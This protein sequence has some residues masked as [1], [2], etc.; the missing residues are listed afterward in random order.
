[1]REQDNE[2]SW[3]RA[4]LERVLAD[5]PMEEFLPAPRAL[6]AFEAAAAASVDPALVMRAAAKLRGGGKLLPAEQEALE[7][8]IR[9]ARPALRFDCGRL[10]VVPTLKLT[11]KERCSIEAMAPGIASVGWSWDIP[12][13]TAFQVAPR[14]L[15]T[16]A[17]VAEKLLHA[18]EDLA[19]GRFVAR[20]DA[21]AQGPRESFP[22]RVSLRSTLWR[23]WR[24]LR[25][26]KTARWS[27]G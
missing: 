24:S 22:S 12:L 1:M 17:H 13:A 7:V 6:V 16:N 15:A 8:G 5:R 26:R 19:C 23:M 14:V 10:P 4:R 20:F 18:W 2:T 9:L 11:E 27:T 21:D 25:W 3:L